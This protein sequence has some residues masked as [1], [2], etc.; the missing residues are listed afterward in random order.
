MAERVHLIDGDLMDQPSPNAA[1]KEA[2]AKE[3]DNFPCGA[4]RTK[5]AAP[6]IPTEYPI[7]WEAL[8]APRWPSRPSEAAGSSEPSC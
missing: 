3:F 4:S 8:D 7:R 6:D 5:N 2:Q 1:V